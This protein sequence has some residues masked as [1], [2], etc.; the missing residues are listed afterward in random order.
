MT[1][2]ELQKLRDLP[3][4]GVTERLGIKV[5]HGRFLCPVHPDHTPSASVSK[6]RTSWKC[7]SC[8]AGGNAIDLTMHVLNK[9]FREACEWLGGPSIQEEVK[10][11]KDKRKM[12]VSIPDSSSPIPISFDASRYE[13]FFAHPFL[14]A[15]A[16]SFLYKERKLDPR[17]VRWC[18]LSSWEDKEGVNWLQIPFFDM[19]GHLTGIQNRNLDYTPDCGLPRFRFPYGSHCGIFNLPVLNRLQTGDELWIA[20]GSSDCLSLLSD[21]KRSIAIGS[22]TLLHPRDKEMLSDLNDR[23]SIQWKMAPDQDIPGHRLFEQLKEILPNLEHV[24]LPQGCKDYSDYYLLKL[25]DHG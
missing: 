16:Q 9:S 2:D 22:A 23:L 5:R 10:R 25:Q 17:V 20:E 11:I 15:K 7:W 19:E 24:A 21:H 14:S 18:R 12:E 6:S 13:R 1:Q 3:I 8:G 4:E